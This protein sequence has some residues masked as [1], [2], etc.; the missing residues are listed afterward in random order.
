M[1][2]CSLGGGWRIQSTG[3]PFTGSA[4][5]YAGDGCTYIPRTLDNP[6]AVSQTLRGATGPGECRY[7]RVSAVDE[8]LPPDFEF[9]C[10]SPHQG[11]AMY[12][13]ESTGRFGMFCGQGALLAL[14]ADNVGGGPQ[15][16]IEQF[17]FTNLDELQFS[18]KESISQ[19]PSGD[20][21]CIVQGGDATCGEGWS[22][23][24]LW[25]SETKC[26]Y[27]PDKEDCDIECPTCE[28]LTKIGCCPGEIVGCS[29]DD[30]TTTETP[31][32]PNEDEADAH[33]EAPSPGIVP[34]GSGSQMAC[35]TYS[36]FCMALVFSLW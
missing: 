31:P 5:C 25:S 23:L 32:G 34:S 26:S 35:V 27:A 29:G 9:Q 16:L 10:E 1:S 12:C 21:E 22:H 36:G 19:A 28:G 7:A 3:G 4:V 18:F 2:I 11:G 33:T 15:M 30:G 6:L 13:N 20:V 14:R 24:Y 17:S 8:F